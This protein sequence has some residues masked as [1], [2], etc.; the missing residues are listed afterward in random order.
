MASRVESAE[1]REERLRRRREH[2]RISSERQTQRCHGVTY[3]KILSHVSLQDDSTVYTCELQ[4]Y[5][6]HVPMCGRCNAIMLDAVSICLKELYI[7]CHWFAINGLVVTHIFHYYSVNDYSNQ[8]I[9]LHDYRTSQ[10]TSP[11]IR[12]RSASHLS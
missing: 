11:R 2:Y 5:R 12:G 4:C 9:N 7:V 3:N 8:V 6:V 1:E 10:N